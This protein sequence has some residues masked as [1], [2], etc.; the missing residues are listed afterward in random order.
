MRSDYIRRILQTALGAAL[1]PLGAPI[2]WAQPPDRLLLNTFQ[3]V[4]ISKADGKP[5]AGVPVVMA[6]AEKGYLY[7]GPHGRLSGAGQD[8]KDRQQFA[9]RDAKTFCDAIT[10][11]EGRSPQGSVLA[12]LE[13]GPS[14]T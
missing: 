2:V 14:L 8:R 1:L 10:D 3:G 5:L 13:D 12:G 11:T 7:I 6:H 9:T 4:V